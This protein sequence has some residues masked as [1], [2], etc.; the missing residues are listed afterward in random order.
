MGSTTKNAT[1]CPCQRTSLPLA[2]EQSRGWIL[3][4]HLWIENSPTNQRGVQ[5]LWDWKE[6]EGV[7]KPLTFVNRNALNPRVWARL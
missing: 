2:Q 7:V 5:C 3:Q 6:Q 1:A 4:Q